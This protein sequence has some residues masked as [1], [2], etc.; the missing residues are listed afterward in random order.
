[1]R[2]GH[3]GSRVVRAPRDRSLW[4]LCA[5][6]VS[7][8]IGPDV[9]SQLKA[10]DLMTVLGILFY[11]KEIVFF[12]RGKNPASRPLFFFLAIA[13]IGVWITMFR[14]GD[15]RFLAAVGLRYFRLVGYT[16]VFAAIQGLVVGRDGLIFLTKCIAGSAV[17]Q[18]ALIFFQHLGLIPTLW[19]REEWMYGRFIP[20][21]TL[22]LNHLNVV[23][24]MTVGAGALLVVI[25][26]QRGALWRLFLGGV[27]LPLMASAILL[28]EARSG[29][30][31]ITL[32]GLFSLRRAKLWP[33]AV[34]LV[35][36]GLVVATALGL[37][38]IEKWDYIWQERVVE[39]GLVGAG[40]MSSNS[41]QQPARV[42]IWWGTIGGLAR[43]PDVLLVGTG[44]QN[45]V[46]INR[47]AVA[48]HCL[49]LHVLVELG[50][51]GLL[52]FGAFFGSVFSL[53]RGRGRNEGEKNAHF[54]GLTVF[55]VL[56]V[57]SLFNETLYPQRAIMGFM[58]YGLSFLAVAGHPGWVWNYRDLGGAG[59]W[60]RTGAGI[61]TNVVAGFSGRCGASGFQSHGH[62]D[63]SGG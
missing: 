21:G 12:F 37:P 62:A 28:G 29:L 33:Q 45:F 53:L 16:V 36:V 15:T 57:L 32:F 5:W 46:M 55:M 3:P 27:I 43:D 17:A 26:I 9:L 19:A 25:L 41:G 38:I 20:T 24:F 22:A 2:R 14:L 48:A 13:F 54:Q 11:R 23:L 40:G 56:L 63:R 4:V 8:T 58:G 59:R 50:I 18:A 10:F 49:P 34:G 60:V 30:V 52:T 47:M 7:F 6:I 42:G 39:K 61:D 44:F 31:A 51:F 1:M 35:L